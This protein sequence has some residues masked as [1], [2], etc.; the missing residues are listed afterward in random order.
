MSIFSKLIKALFPGVV[1]TDSSIASQKKYI[2]E[3]IALYKD[4]FDN[5]D[6]KSLD[7]NQRT[8]VVDNSPRQLVVAGA[9]SGKTLTISAKV[10]YLIDAKGVSPDDILLISFTKKAAEEMHDRIKRLGIEIDSSTFHKYGLGILTQ[11]EK[12]QPDIVDDINEYLDR[13]LSEV[14]FKDEHKSRDFLTLIGLM[15]LP[16]TSEDSNVG[17]KIQL[18]N[19]HNLKTLKELAHGSDKRTLKNEH[20]KSG[21]EVY[22]ANRF[23]LDGI[24][25]EYEAPYKY[26]EQDNYRKKYRPDFY[27]KDVDV[28]W[29]HFGINKNNRA[30]QYDKVHEKE[31]IEGMK[32]KR[33]LHSQNQTKLAETFSWQ[34]T[35]N[36]I[37]E[38]IKANYI[39]FGIKPNPVSYREIINQIETNN[40]Y[41]QF[42]NFK[43]LVTTFVSLYRSYGY[44]NNYFKKVEQ[45]IR[46]GNFISKG[47]DLNWKKK[48]C[49]EFLNFVKGFYNFY[50][51]TLDKEGLIDFN[52]MIL[53][54]SK[55]IKDGAYTP[56][57][58]YVIIDEFQDISFSRYQLIKNTLDVSGAKLFC[59]G[60]DWQSIYRF[61]GSDIDLFINFK[62]YFGTVSR[63]D[64]TKTY[65]NS[66]ELINIS[67]RFILQNRYQLSKKLMSDKQQINPIRII[68][69][70]GSFQP[71][72]GLNNGHFAKNIDEAFDLA[73]KDIQENRD[74]YG[75]DV[76]V[77]GRV[78]NDLNMLSINENVMFKQLSG[79]KRIIHKLYPD[80]NITFRTVHSSKG[81]EADQVIIL[82]LLNDELGFPSQI[83]D[84]PV[85]SVLQ[86]NPE[87]YLYAEER[88]LFYV[89]LTRTRHCTYLLSPE[90][91][92]SI[93]VKE[94]NNIKQ[95]N[96]ISFI[97]P[98]EA[99]NDNTYERPVLQYCPIC[100]T[101]L[102]TLKRANSGRKF[103]GCSNY[104]KCNYAL[105]DINA[106]KNNIRCPECGNFLVQRKGKYGWFLGCSGYPG[107]TYTQKLDSK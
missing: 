68:Y 103:V 102:L 80:L 44:D 5:I 7:D 72:I 81:L 38:S 10:K 88:R 57:Y 37:D 65:R 28:Y 12:K 21:E 71:V 30:P 93:F 86:K 94:L 13:Y 1:N 15:M 90:I 61:S 27:I 11:V 89:A 46:T 74:C 60:D 54:A 22:L 3:E 104:P 56:T 32:W 76:L 58:K 36:S 49:L 84:D 63:T 40:K 77:L 39:K 62:Q 43:S 4:L 106:A 18:E 48:C 42:S 66:R 100:K 20:V 75:S 95:V 82:N 33:N 25:Y 70:S 17:Q 50:V 45:L 26:D 96:E 29:E 34:F 9:G 87:S 101:G 78:N 41:N 99:S 107:C 8:A 2:D 98:D 35:D 97:T 83:I 16:I 23:Y 73:L 19:L 31:Y 47:Y 79:D 52:D 55:Y 24:D 53:K 6:G 67:S 14:I 91:N 64:I 69:Y 59:V 85:I 51:D 92:E 105:R